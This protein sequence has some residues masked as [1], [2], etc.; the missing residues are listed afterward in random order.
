MKKTILYSLMSLILIL[1]SGCATLSD[2]ED[3][4]KDS[5]ASN[6][7]T[8]EAIPGTEIEVD[9]YFFRTSALLTAGQAVDLYIN[10]NEVGEIRNGSNF[11][12]TT[13]SG[14]HEIATKVGV[15]IGLQGVCKFAKDFNLTKQSYYF[16]IDYDTG[17]LCGEYEIIEISKADYDALAAN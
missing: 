11:E 6:K 13:K 9:L 15:S 3:P 16:K 8:E 7:V 1:L 14:S 12:T 4:L 2:I 10:D 5:S 17:I